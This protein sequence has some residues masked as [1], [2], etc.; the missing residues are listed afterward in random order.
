MFGK[1][2]IVPSTWE[3]THRIVHGG[4]NADENLEARMEYMQTGLQDFHNK[5]AHNSDIS[6]SRDRIRYN[7]GV[8]LRSFK[9]GDLIL[10][11]VLNKRISNPQSRW[12][13]RYELTAS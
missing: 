9:V 12:Q 3:A 4:D 8:V 7:S 6:Q 10:K 11:K 13:R 5:T 2:M 1:K